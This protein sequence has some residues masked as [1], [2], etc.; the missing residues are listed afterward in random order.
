MCNVAGVFVQGHM[1]ITSNVCFN[2]GCGHI[3]DCSEF[4]RGINTD[5]VLSYLHMN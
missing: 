2:S 4:I 1:P 3:V 5:T